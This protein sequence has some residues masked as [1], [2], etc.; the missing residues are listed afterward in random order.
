MYQPTAGVPGMSYLDAK[1]RAVEIGRA[2]YLTDI[3]VRG[4]VIDFVFQPPNAAAKPSSCKAED[5][6]PS[7]TDTIGPPYI[8][9][10]G[11]CEPQL[12]FWDFDQA[13]RL[14][15]ALYVIKEQVMQGMMETQ[16]VQGTPAL[17]G[18]QGVAADR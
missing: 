16:R 14:A 8:L 11:G 6:N 7:I 10:F 3:Q 1:N 15:D 2:S 17:F 9:A 4:K 5:I 18:G 13:K 12:V